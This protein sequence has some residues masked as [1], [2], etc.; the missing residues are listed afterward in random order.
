MTLTPN[1]Q[2][3]VNGQQN[4]EVVVNENFVSL[5]HIAVYAMNPDTTTGLT[6]G[7]LGGRWG[8][9]AITAG[10]VSLTGSTTNYLV[11]ARSNGAVS[12]STSITN[13]NNTQTY[14]R[15]FLITT[16]VSTVSTVEDY[17]AGTF[18]VHGVQSVSSTLDSLSD[19]NVPSPSD[20]DVLTYDSGAG[21]WIAAAP[22]GGSSGATFNAIINGDFRVAQRGTTFDST[23]SRNND[24]ALILDRWVL[25][26]DG[27]DTVDVTQES[28]V[29][30]TNGLYAIALDV[31][32]VNRK[33][34]IIQW[35]EQK[36]CVGLIG[37]NVT[38]S[39]KAKV[40][41]TTKLDNVKAA[42]I[43][44]SGTANT[45]TRDVVSAWNIEGTNPTLVANAT[46]ENTP[47]NLN[48]T[49]SYADY[50]ITANVDTASTKNIAI[51]IWSDVTDTTLGD[52]LYITDV[53][54][55][56]GSSASAFVR[57]PY[58]TE[59]NLCLPHCKKIS[60]GNALGLVPGFGY[61]VSTNLADTEISNNPPMFKTPVLTSNGATFSTSLTG[62]VWGV[63]NNNTPGFT[64]ASGAVTL[65]IANESVLGAALRTTAG[66]SLS[67]SSGNIC[68]FYAGTTAN[69]YLDAE[70]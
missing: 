48:L 3:W 13:W 47:A 64:T 30:P 67:G 12:V 51:F 14:A 53:Q 57:R 7:Y 9:N 33:F 68:S 28:S 42:I 27:N 23:S 18:G 34:G 40:S 26:A 61:R 25:L 46:Y 35:I 62:N 69:I 1:M 55:E 56:S 43:A 29:V 6:W 37:G 10:T 65:T 5:Q 38:L 60:Q 2:Q 45:P 21:E 41:S 17:R 32:T 50:S 24:A 70:M 36:N 58:T 15:I 52:F 4:P 54:L 31:E 11:A 8:G 63:Y 19:V 20:G 49:T 44:W 39:F 22:T 59:L 16:G 66:T